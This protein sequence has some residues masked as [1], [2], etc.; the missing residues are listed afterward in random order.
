MRT[1]E[2]AGGG[3]VSRHEFLKVSGAGLAGL[4]VFGAAACSGGMGSE[5]TEDYPSQEVTIIVPYAAG[6]PT[7][8]LA[9]EVGRYFEEEFGETFLVENREGGAATIGINELINSEPDG[10]TLAV[11]AD[12]TALIAPLVEGTIE[13]SVEDFAHI[14]IGYENATVLAVRSDSQYQSAEEFFEAAEENPGELSA[15][16]VGPT[17]SHHIELDR[18]QDEY[19]VNVSRIPFGGDSEIVAALRGGDIDAF[20]SAS[21]EAI[22]PGIEEGDFRALALGGPER[23]DYLPDTPTLRELGYE[24]LTLARS[25]YG[26]VAPQE[27]PAEIIT[28][29]EEGLRGALENQRVRETLGEQYIYDDFVGGDEWRQQ[30]EEISEEYESVLG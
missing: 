1:R 21:G 23:V 8:L 12:P 7:D 17:S 3:N 14:G 19:G 11:I 4:T 6:G 15:G 16:T 22:F 25:I 28:K 24:D 9:R 10:Y 30:R 2:F 27:T 5:S 13:Y 18:L 26:F 29:L 20:F